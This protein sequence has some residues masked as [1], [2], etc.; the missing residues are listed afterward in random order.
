MGRWSS[1]IQWAICKSAFLNTDTSC[2]DA[3]E[4]YRWRKEVSGAEEGNA[5]TR[6]DLQAYV[7]CFSFISLSPPNSCFQHKY[8]LPWKSRGKKTI[9]SF[10]LPEH[11]VKIILKATLSWPV[12]VSIMLNL[13]PELLHLIFPLLLPLTDRKWRLREG[14]EL[15]RCH[16]ANR[17][18]SGDSPSSL[19]TSGRH[20]HCSVTN[21]T[22]SQSEV[23]VPL[24]SITSNRNDQVSRKWS[25]FYN[26]ILLYNLGILLTETQLPHI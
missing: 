10:E 19:L 11:V 8:I 5:N 20:S 6:Q 7:S 15:A 26:Q 21:P 18:E 16:T 24:S 23:H 25:E 22:V 4:T 12:M 1:K 9:P 2:L 17:W 3:P 13:L 14:K